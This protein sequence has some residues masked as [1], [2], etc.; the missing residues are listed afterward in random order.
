MKT[1]KFMLAF[2]AA[3]SLVS[4]PAFAH[5]GHHHKAKMTKPHHA[6]ATPKKADSSMSS[7]SAAEM[8]KMDMKTR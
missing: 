1:I 4:A 8:R 2:G 3:A 5:E 6:S 7:M